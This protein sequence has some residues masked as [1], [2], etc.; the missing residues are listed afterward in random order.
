MLQETDRNECCCDCCAIVFN[1]VS[2]MGEKRQEKGQEEERRRESSEREI[3]Y[4]GKKKKKRTSESAD[5]IWLSICPSACPLLVCPSPY[6]LPVYTHK[7][8]PC[9]L[10][11]IQIVR[12]ILYKKKVYF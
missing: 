8:S 1:C 7:Y 11:D 6:D 12:V 3:E 4:K 2:W 5:N 10:Y 9:C